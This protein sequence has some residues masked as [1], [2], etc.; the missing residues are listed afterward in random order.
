[1]RGLIDVVRKVQ[2][3]QGMK[4]G[5]LNVVKLAGFK[6]LVKWA[7]NHIEIKK[8]GKKG[9]GKRAERKCLRPPKWNLCGMLR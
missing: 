2:K 3:K 1:V 7:D 8:A 9:L 5:L 4:L 6:T